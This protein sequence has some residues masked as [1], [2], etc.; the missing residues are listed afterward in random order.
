M[1]AAQDV[2]G[3]Q[4]RKAGSVFFGQDSTCGGTLSVTLGI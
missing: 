2:H 1:R 3:G 4:G